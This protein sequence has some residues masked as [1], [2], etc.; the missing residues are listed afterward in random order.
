MDSKPL[1]E[2]NTKQQHGIIEK[3]D[4]N[5]LIFLG[6][7]LFAALFSL[8][9]WMGILLARFESEQHRQQELEQVYQ[10]L[11]EMR[12]S[13]KSRVYENIY[14]VLSV[15]SIVE[16]NPKLTQED[17][18]RAMAVQ[19]RGEHDLRNIGLAKD[20]VL[21]LMYP[22]EGNESAI[23]LDYTTL[24]EQF[25]AVDLA[26]RVNEIVLAGPLPLVQG[27]E[28]VIAR[29]PIYVTNTT[30]EKEEFWGFASAVMDN[31]S[32]F[33]GAG[34][35]V[36]SGI[37]RVALRGRDALGADGEI[38]WGDPSVFQQ[39]PIA[40]IVDLPYG[41][42]QIAAI[43]SRGWS[44]YAAFSSRTIWIYLTVASTL[45]AFTAIIL[46]LLIRQKKIVELL[47]KERN[48]FAA[49]PV[50]SVEFDVHSDT[51]LSIKNVS[52][53]VE[54]VLGYNAAEILHPDFSYEVLLHPED[55]ACVINRLKH[56][57]ENRIDRFEESYRIKTKAGHY[58]W[59]YDFTLLLRDE[60][61]NLLGL[62]SYLYD[63][64]AQK[65]A[66]EALRLAEERLEK[67]AYELT[68]NI[69][70]GTYTMVQP[71]DGGM[72]HFAFMSSRFL[73]LTGVSREEAAADPMKGF[74]CVHP[75]DLDRWIALNVETFTEKKP[76]FGETRIIV[77]G[78]VRWITAESFPRTLSDGKTVWEG[79]LTDITDRKRAEEALSESLSRFNDLVEH[80]SVGVYV[81]WHR[82]SGTMEFEYISDGWCIMNQLCREDVQKNPFLAWEVIHPEEIEYFRV[83]NQEV[84]RERKQFSWEGR[85]IVGGEERF[86]LIESTPIFFDNGD[87]RWFGIQQDVTERKTAEATLHATNAALEQEVA[88][89]KLIEEQLKVKS[90]MLKRLSI[91]DGLTGIP[92]RRHFDERAALEWQRTQRNDTHL[93]L[94]MM[95]IDHFKKYNDGYGHGAGD[96]CLKRVAQALVHS[97]DRAMDLV[98]RY[99]GEEFVALLPETDHQGALYLAEKMRCAVEALAI[100]HDFSSTAKNVT[101]SIGVAVHGGGSSKTSLEQLQRCADQALYH[102]KHQGR[103]QVQREDFVATDCLRPQTTP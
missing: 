11:D 88:E 58:L 36:D 1:K 99:G 75:D 103:N 2:Q 65:Q 81:F 91:Q 41:S 54:Q 96:E 90:E 84:V 56:N 8:L 12:L 97:C 53:N 60:A 18:A 94:I 42:W 98:A 74:A 34:I 79:V 95:D 102:A 40:Q 30:S 22:I 72:A 25:D 14:K 20:M 4:K 57:I 92:N 85:V 63:Q 89:R 100:P 48:L 86:M 9:V 16:M 51:S 45:L 15:R 6:A 35:E 10:R 43:P 38:F 29:I 67:T 93:A 17:F 19:F 82:A 64:S 87:S 59:L 33:A 77:N 68:E 55:C 27:G 32:I 101:L 78:E 47:E 21:Q 5:S 3:R 13:L 31:E 69:P 80:V 28:G 70:V 83:Y 62:Y 50:F 52:S 37:L 61:G 26:L 49:G 46:L 7:A 44:S 71:A 23:G 73:Q 24:P 39:N 66:E 76:F